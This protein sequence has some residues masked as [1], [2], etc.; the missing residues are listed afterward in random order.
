MANKRKPKQKRSWLKALL[1]FIFVPIVVWSAAFL[2]WLNWYGVMALLGK[3]TVGVKPAA[4]SSR[5]QAPKPGPA[6][7]PHET[8][9]EEDRRQL[10]EIL[11]RR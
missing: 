10:E 8:I 5:D 11:K 4:N 7:D 3:G 6:Q 9:Q 2:L 1:L